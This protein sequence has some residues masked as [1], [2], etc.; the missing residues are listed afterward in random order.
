MSDRDTIFALA[1]APGKAGVAVLR[2]SGCQVKRVAKNLSISLPAPRYAATRAL[3][4]RDQALL[5]RGLVLFFPAGNSFT[6][7]DV[8]E[9]HMHGSMAVVRALLRELSDM[10]GLRLARAGEFTRR[11]LENDRLDVARVEGLADLIDAETEAQ[12][13][14]AMRILSGD[15]GKISQTWRE[16]LTRAASLIEASIDFVDEDLPTD[17]RPEVLSLLDGTLQSLAREMMGISA[18]QRIRSGFE[19]AILGAPNVGKSTVLNALAGRPA[20]ITSAYAGTTRDVIEVQMDLDG[21]L[22]CFLDTAGLRETSDPVEQMG[23]EQTLKRAEAADLRVVL[24]EAGTRPA[25]APR[26][27]DIVLTAKADLHGNP[28]QSISG[29]TG[30]GLAPLLEQIKKEL[31]QRASIAGVA[32]QQRHRTAMTQAQSSLHEAKTLLNSAPDRYDI[33]A[34]EIHCAIRALDSLIGRVDTET[35]LDEIFS[36]FCIGK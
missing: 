34:E 2:I 33:I 29:K 25:L 24:T 23:I 17:V 3:K 35:I 11:A 9:L 4:D 5:D 26:C 8:L 6:G 31:S 16:D 22:V 18:A 21:L 30:F 1:T 27:G 10:A 12:R 28:K 32:T 36:R 7:E 20:A 14:Q 13:R 19:V 15:L